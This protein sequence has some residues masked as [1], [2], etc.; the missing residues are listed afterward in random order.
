MVLC[1]FPNLVASYPTAVD[2][3]KNKYFL[4][5]QRLRLGIPMLIAGLDY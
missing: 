1:I 4:L 5:R 2:F 3:N